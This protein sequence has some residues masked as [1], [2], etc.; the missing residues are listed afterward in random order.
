MRENEF[1]T[2]IDYSPGTLPLQISDDLAIQNADRIG[3]ID[4][5]DVYELKHQNERLVF[6]HSNQKVDAYVVLNGLDLRAVRNISGISGAVTALVAF[7]THIE[8]TPIR[9][10]ADEPLTPE[11][12]RWLSALIKKGGRGLSFSANGKSVDLAKL[13]QEWDAARTGDRG[14]TEIVIESN[15]ANRRFRTKAASGVFLLPSPY[16]LGD[17]EII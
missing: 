9:I 17:I 4:G 6:F 12:F 10:A 1:I 3:E 14:P 5:R 8:K 15:M 11:G 13:E 16:Y 7:I 2:E